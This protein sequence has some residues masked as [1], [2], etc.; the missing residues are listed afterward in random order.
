MSRQLHL[1]R[2][3]NLVQVH[4]SLLDGRVLLYCIDPRTHGPITAW[5]AGTDVGRR[6]AM[7]MDDEGRAHD[8]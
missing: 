8:A 4:R 1:L 5:L 6:V 3:A 2:D 7:T